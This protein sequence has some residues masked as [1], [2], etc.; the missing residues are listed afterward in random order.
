MS[1]LSVKAGDGET[2]YSSKPADVIQSGSVL[3]GTSSSGSSIHLEDYTTFSGDV[4]DPDRK[5][6]DM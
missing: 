5:F 1:S 2:V 3:Q 4:A 6:E